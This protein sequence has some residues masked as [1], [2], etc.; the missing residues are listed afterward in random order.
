M[1]LRL[2]HTAQ[3][4]AVMQ[5]GVIASTP[6]F[7]LHA[8]HWH[9]PE[10]PTHKPL[11]GAG[12]HLGVLVPKRH[13]KRAVTRST[14]KRQMRAVFAAPEAMP[15]CTALVVRMRKEFDRKI[16]TSATSAPLRFAVR[17]ELQTLLAHARWHG[18]KTVPMPYTQIPSASKPH[19]SSV[20]GTIG[21]A[22]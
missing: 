14:I 4:Q 18:V 15:T 19:R 1:L 10:E 3:F 6:H 12:R 22:L 5:A 8:M 13:A 9:P 2:Q 20:S 16:F 7:V 17:A 11:I 21:T